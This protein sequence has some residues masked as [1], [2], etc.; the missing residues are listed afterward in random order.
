MR[1]LGAGFQTA[2]R[3]FQPC[4]AP[5]VFR[6]SCGW[7]RG[8]FSSQSRSEFQPPKTIP[9]E[10]MLI[11]KPLPLAWSSPAAAGVTVLCPR[12]VWVVPCIL[13]DALSLCTNRRPPVPPLN[14]RRLP[15]N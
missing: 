6:R 15:S 10:V 1:E 4:S 14:I 11:L 8:G 5:L 9:H 2:R 13:E 7:Q 12:G 3:R